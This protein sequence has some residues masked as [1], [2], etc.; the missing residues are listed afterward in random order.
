[1]L[2]VHG[3]H[4]G[5][6]RYS[7]LLRRA[8][9]EPVRGVDLQVQ[10]GELVALVGASGA[11]KSLLAH[12]LLGILPTNAHTHG[13]L[14]LD[15]EALTP[16][17]LAELRGRQI[18][19]VP[20]SLTFLDPLA[21]ARRQVRWAALAA[22][23]PADD[24]AVREAL[25]RYGLPAEAAARYPHQLSGGMAR[26]VLNAMATVA[27]ARLL[28]ADEPTSGLDPEVSALS[29]SHLRAL[30]DGGRGVLVITHDL[31]AVLPHADK[32]VILED[33]RSVETTTPS[34]FFAGRLAHAY[35]RALR[36]ALPAYGFG[37]AAVPAG[38]ASG[39]VVLHAADLRHQWPKATRPLFEGLD[40]SLAAGEWQA[41]QGPSGCGKTTLARLLAGQLP[42]QHGRID[43][44]PIAGSAS[45]RARPV[46]W[47]HQHAELAFNPRRRVGDSLAEGWQPDTRTLQRFGIA[48]GWLQR[49][50]H[51]LSGGELQ[52]LNIVRALVP[53]LRVLIAD[54]MTAM[55][56]AITQASLWHGLREALAGRD[57]AVLVISHDTALLDA[58][59]V[60]R[61]SVDFRCA[62]PA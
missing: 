48:T 25:H 58:L 13:R 36:A 37:G 15:G 41:L 22:G 52:R 34:H 31:Q 59:G 57:V 7:G 54:E 49:F 46:Q 60:R 9:M 20:Q 12:A 29:L 39:P 27:Q 5:F 33:G 21:Q 24:A 62:S 55:H 44:P 26:R 28:I 32:L 35:S 11:G 53:G 6:Q 3:L 17:R 40:L 1:M 45:S 4:I 16:R 51:E 19:L 42:L 43:L 2:E 10:A 61:L 23:Q 30:A 8:W 38:K 14:L 50:P 18:A 56:D 47:L